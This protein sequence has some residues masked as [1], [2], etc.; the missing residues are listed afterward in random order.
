MKSYEEELR[1][2]DRLFMLLTLMVV[3]ATVALLI[4]LR[5]IPA[6]IAADVASIAAYGW[7]SYVQRRPFNKDT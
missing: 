7:L 6:A 4:D 3:A 5:F 2:A 1:R